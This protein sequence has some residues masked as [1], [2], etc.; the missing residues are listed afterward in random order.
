MLTLLP[1]LPHSTTKFLDP[2]TTVCWIR[3][4]SW[5]GMKPDLARCVQPGTQPSPGVPGLTQCIGSRAR[6]E[7]GPGPVNLDPC[8]GSGAV[9]CPRSN[10]WSKTWHTGSNSAC[11]SNFRGRLDFLAAGTHLNGR[12]FYPSGSPSKSQCVLYT[13]PCCMWQIMICML[14]RILFFFCLKMSLVLQ[15]ADWGGDKRAGCLK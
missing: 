13:G 10:M 4:A 6:Y 15:Q 5:V 2:S 3:L 7:V 14:G 8:T 12:C 1:P 11:G 9:C